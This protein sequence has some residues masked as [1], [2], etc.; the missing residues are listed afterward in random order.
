VAGISGRRFGDGPLHEL[1]LEGWQ[2]V[3]ANNATSQMLV[4]RAVVR[5]MLTQEPVA[6]GQRGVILNMSSVLAR[7]PSA[8]FFS[9]HAYAASKGAI[10]SMSRAMAAYY[11]PHAIRV[12]AIAPA[13][14]ATPMSGRAQSDPAIMDFVARKQPLAGGALS[15]ADLTGTALFLLSDESRAITGQVVDVDGGWSISEG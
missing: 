10:E 14:V 13:L 7:H 2:T 9:T 8:E 1:T 4:S 6:K 15:A 3:L 12:N 5:Q 11:A